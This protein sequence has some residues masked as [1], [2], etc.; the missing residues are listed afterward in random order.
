M[1]QQIFLDNH[2][3]GYI[4]KWRGQ[5][6]KL[7]KY[8]HTAILLVQLEACPMIQAQHSAN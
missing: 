2:H 8:S 5:K 6:E 3:F 1:F 4:T 7:H